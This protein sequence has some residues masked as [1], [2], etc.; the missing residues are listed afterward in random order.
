[1]ES[2][3]APD[4]SINSDSAAPLFGRFAGGYFVPV[5]NMSDS[6]NHSLDDVNID[7]ACENTL[8][9]CFLSYDDTPAFHDLPFLENTYE[10]G[11]PSKQSLFPFQEAENDQQSQY[12][13]SS[14]RS[15][16]LSSL[17]SSSGFPPEPVPYGDQ[18]IS[19][20]KE[21]ETSLSEQLATDIETCFKQLESP[22]QENPTRYVD[23][24]M[25]SCGSVIS[26]A[27]PPTD[28]QASIMQ[29]HA[30]KPSRKRGRKPSSLSAEEKRK[31]RLEKG[32]LAAN[33]C[34]AKKRKLEVE[35]EYIERQLLEERK[36][37]LQTNES[38][39]R[40]IERLKAEAAKRVGFVNPCNLEGVLGKSTEL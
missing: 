8:D 2:T 21:L 23:K 31:K 4:F 38:L 6:L 29:T 18:V 26:L 7:G 22:T 10:S 9:P 14:S 1:M 20:L 27:K 17:P 5:P 34:R 32:R 36:Q 19:G 3:Y 35:L 15:Y 11:L 24:A 25:S 12:A 30:T 33:K 13:S 16:S 40:E 39:K 37:L 28:P